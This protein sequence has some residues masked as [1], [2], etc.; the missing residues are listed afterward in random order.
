MSLKFACGAEWWDTNGNFQYERDGIR[1]EYGW[2]NR[3]YFWLP[4]VL[5]IQL[6]VTVLVS[7]QRRPESNWS[8]LVDIYFAAAILNNSLLVAGTL[9]AKAVGCM[10]LESG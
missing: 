4:W 10:E 8:A 2:P 1:I 3:D 9:A 6:L 5:A 7:I